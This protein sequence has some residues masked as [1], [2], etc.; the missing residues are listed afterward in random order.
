LEDCE[1]SGKQHIISFMPC[2]KYFRIHDKKEFANLMPRYFRHG[3]L[4]SF[5]RQLSIYRFT[6]Q[7]KGPCRG[8]YGH[9]YFIRGRTDLC[10]LITRNDKLSVEDSPKSTMMSSSEKHLPALFD[11][12]PF[13]LEMNESKDLPLDFDIGHISPLNMSIVQNPVSYGSFSSTPPDILDEI[14][15][16]F[17]V[18]QASF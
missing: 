5:L 15:T 14:I 13:P 9:P 17:A 7:S 8:A 12:S 18:P 10:R 16:T 2:G 4:K 3:K 11:D 6:R 1:A